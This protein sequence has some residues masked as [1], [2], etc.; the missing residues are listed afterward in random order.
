MSI[1]N[2]TDKIYHLL[3]MKEMHTLGVLSDEQ[4]ADLIKTLWGIEEKY[5]ID[6]LLYFDYETWGG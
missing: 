2:S 5:G 6:E 4:Y 1:F 3:L